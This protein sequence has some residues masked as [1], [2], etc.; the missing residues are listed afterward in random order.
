MNL[1][2]FKY[3]LTLSQEGSFS[4]AA[5]TLNISQPSLSQYI[6]KI[7]KEIGA[8]LFIRANGEV[9]LT[10]AGRVYLETGKKILA[11]QRQME[12]ELSDI[13]DNLSG[14]VTV[15]ISPYRSV[16][17]IPRVLKEFNRSYPGIKLVVKERSGSD[18]MES[19]LH[20]EFD[21][22]II[23]G[24]VD[25]KIFNYE[26][27]QEEEIVIAVN[28]KTELY[29]SL[30]N[31]AEKIDG[32][33]FPAVDIHLADGHDFAM[34]APYMPMR[35]I[36]DDMLSRFGVEVREK[37]QVSSNEAL[38]SVVH[39]ETCASFIPSG[40]TGFETEETAFFSIKQ[41]V[42]VRSVAAIYRKDQYLSKPTMDLIKIFKAFS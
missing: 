30:E 9:R 42:G 17:M 36:T 19:A 3:V 35:T 10:D 25:K 1:K 39:S 21:V 38:L 28:K 14:T 27:V 7:E 15:G 40:L 23:A 26:V 33:Q 13:T 41:E 29:R 8:D 2:Q 31:E 22:C 18:L 4:R 20:G 34:L 5:E 11:L 12:N 6:K 37:V 16:H 24:P 32:K